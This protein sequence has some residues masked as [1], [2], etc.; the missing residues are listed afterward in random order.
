VARCSTSDD[1]DG[2]RQVAVE[3]ALSRVFPLDLLAHE[4]RLA[5]LLHLPAGNGAQSGPAQRLT[6]AQAEAGVVQWAANGI[7]DE[8]AF[9]ER[10][11]VM[12]AYRADGEDVRAAP[13]DQ[14]RLVSDVA[15]SMTPS[16][17]AASAIPCV[18]SGPLDCGASDMRTSY[19]LAVPAICATMVAMQEQGDARFSASRAQKFLSR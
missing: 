12:R 3:R 17:T 4:D 7:V 5:T 9:G 16:T 13:R 2:T 15:S 11:A 14:N 8:E 19:V 18:K 10:S 1:D 6:G